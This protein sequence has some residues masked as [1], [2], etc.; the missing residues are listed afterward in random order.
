MFFKFVKP[1]VLRK[2]RIKSIDFVEIE[3]KY[4]QLY[5]NIK[6][7]QKLSKTG[8]WIWIINLERCLLLMKLTKY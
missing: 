8:S 7:G 4:D 1:K 5:E 6:Y 2:E 3:K